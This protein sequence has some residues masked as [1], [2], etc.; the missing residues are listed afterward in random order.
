MG[1]SVSRVDPGERAV[2]FLNCLTHTGDYAGKPFSLRPWQESPIRR[3]FG[4]LRPDGTRQYRKTFWALPRK[5]GKTE[6]VAGASI[7]LLMGQ[8]K[9]NQKIYTASGDSEQAALIFGAAKEMIQNDPELAE[10]TVVYE[11]YK[12]IDYPE[13]NSSLKVLSSVPKSKHGLGPTAVLIDEYHVVDEE[14]VNVLTTGFGARKEPLTWMITTAGWDQHSLCYDEWQYALKVQRGEIDDPTYLPVV[15][16][17]D[18]ADDWRDEAT[19]AKAMPAL[20][21]FC[22]L[23]FIREECKKAQERPRFENSF[24]QLYLNLWTEQSQRWLQIERWKECGG[25][26]DKVLGGRECYAGLDLG[27]TGDM[28]ALARVFPN[29][30]GGLDVLCRFWVPEEGRWRQEARNRSLYKQWEKAGFLTFTSGESADFDQIEREILELN[31]ITPFRLLCADRAY[32]TQLLSRLFN[33]HGLPVKGIPQG[34]ITLNEPMTRLEAM[35]LDRSLR[36]TGDPVLAW[37]VANATVKTAS[38]GLMHLDKSASTSR[39]DGLAAVIDAVAAYIADPDAG[40]SVY[41]S[42][43]IR[44][45]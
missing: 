28:S 22:N 33:N 18:P 3:L 9:P 43:G 14:L 7:Y 31:E 36:H 6:I 35:I 10:R 34:P 4:T 32:A 45:I 42:R 15:H 19:W 24:K 30:L 16:A 21:D 12:R 20:G 39:I 1:C 13:G 25:L 29:D 2:R 44:C 17:A 8:G 38:T 11:G 37:N 41:E 5:Q 27:V 23:E 26:D 40:E